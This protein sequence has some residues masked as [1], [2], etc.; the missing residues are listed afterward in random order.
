MKMRNI[1]GKFDLTGNN[2]KNL[3]NILAH[4]NLM[5]VHE[6]I[7]SIKPT[8]KNLLMNN[9]MITNSGHNKR[10]QFNNYSSKSNMLIFNP[11]SLNSILK[12]K[13]LNVIS[14]LNNSKTI[15]FQTYIKKLKSPQVHLRLFRK[16]KHSVKGIGL[17]SSFLTNTFKW[18]KKILISITNIKNQHKTNKESIHLKMPLTGAKNNKRNSNKTQEEMIQRWWPKK[19]SMILVHMMIDSRQIKEI[20]N[21]RRPLIMQNR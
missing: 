18:L 9:L 17:W 13:T 3:T 10:I 16:E 14:H 21:L 15:L 5:H 4:T 20:N 2:N 7:Q 1:I 6:A 19:I 11:H 8:N 12:S